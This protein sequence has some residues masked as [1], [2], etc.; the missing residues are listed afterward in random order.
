MGGDGLQMIEA[1]GVCPDTTTSDGGISENFGSKMRESARNDKKSRRETTRPSLTDTDRASH[2]S[3]DSSKTP[4]TQPK[5]Q[6]WLA[7]LRRAILGML[8]YASKDPARK[9]LVLLVDDLHLIDVSLVELVADVA[10]TLQAVSIIASRN[11]IVDDVVFRG[12]QNEALAQALHVFRFA[13][14]QCRTG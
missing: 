12:G 4:P 11:P 2:G 5:V 9:P 13:Q 10:V 6:T 3:A 7:V 14:A 1:Y 8:R